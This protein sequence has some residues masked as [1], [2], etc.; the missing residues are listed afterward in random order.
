MPWRNEDNDLISGCKTFEEK[1]EQVKHVVFKNRCQFEFH[2]DILD[3]A[4][5]DLD[6]YDESDVYNCSVAPN[7]Q[8][9]NEQGQIV[10]NRP[11]DLF[12]CFDPGPQKQHSQYDLLDDIGIFPRC[13]SSEEL[14]TNRMEDREYRKLVRLIN[15]EQKLFFL[16]CAAL[17]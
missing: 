16:S 5:D 8:H 3:K 1:Y 7:A 10:G 12:G 14:V 15:N 6:C 9:I 17:Y 11:S 13:S 2:S 4:F